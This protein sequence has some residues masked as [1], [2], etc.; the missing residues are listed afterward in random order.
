MGVRN[1]SVIQ[2]IAMALSGPSWR[3]S[4][5]ALLT[6]YYDDTGKPELPVVSLFGF[7]ASAEQWLRFDNDWRAVLAL[8]QFQL[9]YF[10]MREIRQARRAKNAAFHKFEDNDSLRRDLFER[11]QRV[12]RVRVEQ[13]FSAVVLMD[14]YRR[15]NS[16]FEIEEQIGTPAAAATA[17][18]IGK[19]LKW[20]EHIHPDKPFKVVCD[21]GMD[22]W[23]KL[24]QTVYSEWGFRLV[25][26]IV[27][28]VPGLQASD[29]A[30]WEL[31]R[32]LSDISI[33]KIRDGI[34][35]RPTFLKFLEQFTFSVDGEERIPWFLI[36]GEQ[37]NRYVEKF[38][39][40]KRE[41]PLLEPPEPSGVQQ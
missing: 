7:V 35:V 13:A 24:D 29:F 30:A 1:Y 17:V 22:E 26:G 36:D 23:G 32:V 12:I 18:A 10:H 11:L 25:P 14:D 28:E 34:G 5:F 41:S 16:E 33:G 3:S 6:A 8:P 20:R 31:Q 38:S 27:K 15:L 2:H 21:Q 4:E 9:P 37:L 40:P 39:V 19:F